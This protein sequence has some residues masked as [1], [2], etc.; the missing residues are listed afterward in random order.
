MTRW[1]LLKDQA[2]A[3]ITKLGCGEFVVPAGRANAVYCQHLVVVGHIWIRGSNIVIGRLISRYARQQSLSAAGN[4]S[5]NSIAANVGVTGVGLG[6]GEMDDGVDSSHCYQGH[7]R[8]RFRMQWIR[9]IE[10]SN[11]PASARLSRDYS[12]G[13]VRVALRCR[14]CLSTCAVGASIDVTDLHPS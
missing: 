10:V 13:R 5:H 6:P 14:G 12:P 8:R 1:C 4:A 7:A 11:E 2:S 9:R 3:G